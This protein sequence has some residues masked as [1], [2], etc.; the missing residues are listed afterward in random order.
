MLPEIHAPGFLSWCADLL[1]PCFELS[2]LRHGFGELYL[3]VLSVSSCSHGRS[4][5]LQFVAR[6]KE[7][8]G[9]STQLLNLVIL[10]DVLV[11]L[12]RFQRR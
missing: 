8:T 6:E 3:F 7:V 5:V 10:R 2:I 1:A 4:M 12:G 11:K 9:S